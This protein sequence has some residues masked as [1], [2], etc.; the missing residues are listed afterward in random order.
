MIGGKSQIPVINVESCC[1]AIIKAAEQDVVKSDVH[2]QTT[3]DGELGAFEAINL[4]DSNCPTQ[5]EYMRGLSDSVEENRG[6][7]VRFPWV[8]LKLWSLLVELLRV[9]FPS[10]VK[11]LPTAMRPATIAARFKPLR[12]R[13]Q[14]AVDRLEYAEGVEISNVF[15][16]VTT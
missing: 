13:N 3:A 5:E 4:V 14:R 6:L 11:A 9:P 10:V 15:S 8:V 12:F 16:K 7:V 1:C 2:T